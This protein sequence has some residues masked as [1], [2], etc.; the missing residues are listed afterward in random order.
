MTRVRRQCIVALDSRPSTRQEA[1]PLPEL[2][3][4]LEKELTAT[5]E[6]V[7]LNAVKKII[8]LPEFAENQVVRFVKALTAPLKDR[9]VEVRYY[10]KKAYSRLK[11]M[12]KGNARGLILPDSV[13]MPFDSMVPTPT[14]VYGSRDFWTYEIT[15]VDFKLRVKAIMECAK[16]GS[17][18]AYQRIQKLAET[19]TDEQVLAT[20]AKYL[21]F[22]KRPGI[23]ERVVE[24]LKHPD[25]RVRANTIE[26]LE[27]LN[28][29][30]AIPLVMPFLSDQDNRVKGN[31]VKYLVK[32]HPDEV[33][34]A[35]GEML[36]ST[37]VWMRDS[38][39]FLA[40]KIDL[41]ISEDLLLRA[42]KDDASEIVRKAIAAL[43]AQARTTKVADAL[44]ELTHFTSEKDLGTA[45][46]TAADAVR[47]RSS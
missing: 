42:L 32:S 14:F 16:F 3:D 35:L 9:S 2:Y 34:K 4:H 45:A 25:E 23:F 7:R 39:V 31:A 36:S 19:E 11:S 24:Y 38:A 27:I 18:A 44:E 30:R 17:E 8:T 37:H 41:T 6:V 26:G 47:K 12:I 5:D 43:E 28:D 29:P 21:P 33:R 13:D 46:R 22:F 10:A 40:G 20:I 15:S 1:V